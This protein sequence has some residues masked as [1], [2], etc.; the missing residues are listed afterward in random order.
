MREGNDHWGEMIFPGVY[1]IQR[2]TGTPMTSGTAQPD[3]PVNLELVHLEIDETEKYIELLKKSNH[4]IAAYLMEQKE[5]RST[6]EEGGGAAASMIALSDGGVEEEDDEAVFREALE[7]NVLVI[8]R[9]KRELAQLRALIEGQRC[10]CSC[11]HSK[12]VDPQ[13]IAAPNDESRI[14][15]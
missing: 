12:S 14:A 6:E 9:K 4:E 15:L 3:N 13:S 8:A 7:E 10:G 1:M 11:A 5:R 2:S